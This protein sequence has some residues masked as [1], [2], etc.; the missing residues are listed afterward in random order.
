MDKDTKKISAAQQTGKKKI[1]FEDWGGGGYMIYS[2]PRND[3]DSDSDSIQRYFWLFLILVIQVNS[4]PMPGAG[5][6]LNGFCGMSAYRLY[7]S[8]GEQIRRDLF[9]LARSS[10]PSSDSF[11]TVLFLNIHDIDISNYMKFHIFYL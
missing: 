7:A 1:H 3:S 8:R 10:V 2:G 6:T 4:R 9:R 11:S 5:V